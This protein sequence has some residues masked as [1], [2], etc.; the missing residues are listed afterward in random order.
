M[1]EEFK[2]WR[3]QPTTAKVERRHDDIWFF[4]ADSGWAVNSDGKAIKTSDGGISWEEKLSVHGDDVWLRCIG[5]A[6][7]KRGWIGSTTSDNRLYQTNDGGDNWQAVTNL[8]DST[9][10]AICGLSVVNESIIYAS[11]TNW[12]ERPTGIIK[13]IDGGQNWTGWNMD[14]HA[15]LLVDIYFKDPQRG[16]V[17]GGKSDFPNPE[18]KDVSPI[19]LYTENGGVTWRE[20]E[21]RSALP[22]GEW[23]WK[24]FFVNEKIGFVSLENFSGGAI[25]KTTDAGQTWIRYCINDQQGNVNLEGIGFVNEDLG[26]VGGWANSSGTRDGGKT[27]EDA[28][29]IGKFLNRFRFIGNPVKVGYASGDSIYKFTKEKVPELFSLKT[30]QGRIL[31]LDR[32]SQSSRPLEIK[33]TVPKNANRISIN[34]WD[35]FSKLVRKLLNEK[36]P[37]PGSHSILWDG[38]SESDANLPSG[39]YCYRVSIDSEAESRFIHLE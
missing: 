23:G 6:D 15:A 3:W 31:D 38:T 13:S 10:S 12:P 34:I 8:P 1:N 24:I 14:E 9:P 20:T 16:W 32:A 30:P 5:F 25:L 19:V 22:L 17:V 11:G 36:N 7:Q 37:N 35:R 4:D 18:R 39:F 26:W 27:W 28:N 29:Q 2:G 33:Y 21:I